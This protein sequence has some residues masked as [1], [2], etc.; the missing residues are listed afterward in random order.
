M[1]IPLLLTYLLNPAYAPKL[2][3]AFTCPHTYP[4]RPMIWFLKV[5][6]SGSFNSALTLGLLADITFMLLYLF[7]LS[8]SLIL[9]SSSWFSYLSPHKG[10]IELTKNKTKTEPRII[11]REAIS[12]PILSIYFKGITKTAKRNT[13]DIGCLNAIINAIAKT[14][15]DKTPNIFFI[16][17]PNR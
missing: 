5:A 11:K 15:K 16:F 10:T 8:F 2:F 3:L 13:I 12:P 6:D 4:S 14:T 7:C 9:I 1:V 17:Y